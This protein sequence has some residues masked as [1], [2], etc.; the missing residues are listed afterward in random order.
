[1]KE[2]R[3]LRIVAA[4]LDV[5]DPIVQRIAQGYTT[6]RQRSCATGEWW[7]NTHPWASW[8]D[9]AL[10]LYYAGE[11][12]ALEKVSQY[13]SKGTHMESVQAGIVLY[14]LVLS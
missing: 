4:V 9:L 3:D 5:P 2:V 6:E 12:R 10:T 1:M 11:D 13:L 14:M 7:V 8:D